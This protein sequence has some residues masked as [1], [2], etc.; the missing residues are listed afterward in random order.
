LQIEPDLAGQKWKYARS[1]YFEI[2]GNMQ[3]RNGFID[4]DVL[5][6][7]QKVVIIKP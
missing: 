3:F 1:R 6:P 7:P 5:P 4:D 2:E